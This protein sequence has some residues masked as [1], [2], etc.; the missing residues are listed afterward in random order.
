MVLLSAA[1]ASAQTDPGTRLIVHDDM[2]PASLVLHGVA[3]DPL[4]PK[5]GVGLGARMRYVNVPDRVF[6][7]Y[8][9]DHTSFDS[10][11]VG[12]EVSLDGPARSRVILGLDYTSLGMPAGN[13]R[14][15]RFRTVSLLGFDGDNDGEQPEDASFT[16]IDLHLIALDAMFMWKLPIVEQFGFHY[17]IGF[18]LGYMP[19]TVVSTDVLPTCQ[20]PEDVSKCGHWRDV[21]RREQ[22]IPLRW[23]PLVTANTGVYYDPVPKVRIRLDVGVRWM[24]Y[25]GLSVRSTF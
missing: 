23:I 1:I 5:E 18:G 3:A 21:T 12:L 9:L 11:S 2:G 6:E 10:Y 7:M 16:E 14:L 13:W 19:G 24:I 20:E 17:G 8:A 15:G 4:E 22:K 25:T